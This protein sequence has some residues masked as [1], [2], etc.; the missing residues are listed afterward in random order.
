[1]EISYT[2]FGE[3]TTIDT[4]GISYPVSANDLKL[5]LALVGP[6]WTSHIS[7]GVLHF[8]NIV[9]VQPPVTLMTNI[10]NENLTTYILQSGNI[11]TTTIRIQHFA[12]VDGVNTPITFSFTRINASSLVSNNN[13]YTN[14]NTTYFTLSLVFPAFTESLFY[15]PDF[16]IV[17]EGSQSFSG[18]G[19]SNLLPLLALLA[20]LIPIAFFIFGMI[21]LVFVVVRRR[22]MRAKVHSM[23]E[24]SM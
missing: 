13:N 4:A 8:N 17:L 5:D 7:A 15:D 10:S 23:I 18:D 2:L 3:A 24:N 14:P 6:G 21:V 22:K 19:G 1:M 11:Q 16:S 9:T 20:L 12:V